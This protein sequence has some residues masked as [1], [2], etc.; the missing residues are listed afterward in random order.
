MIDY[1]VSIPCIY[2][3]LSDHIVYECNLLYSLMRGRIKGPCPL[4]NPMQSDNIFVLFTMSCYCRPSMLTFSTSLQYNIAV[5]QLYHA[6]KGCIS[7]YQL[8]LTNYYITTKIRPIVTSTA[9]LN[10]HRAIVEHFILV[11]L[12]KINNPGPSP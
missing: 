12:R 6:C 7:F 1:Y 8:S 3:L 4:V 9:C 10:D 11:L 2:P 5:N